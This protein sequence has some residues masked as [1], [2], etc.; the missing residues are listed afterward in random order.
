MGDQLCTSDLRRETKKKSRK[1]TLRNCGP[2]LSVSRGQRWLCNMLFS[3]HYRLS[4]C[5]GVPVSRHS[6]RNFRRVGMRLIAFRHSS[7]WYIRSAM[8]LLGSTL[9]EIEL[10]AFS[11]FISRRCC[12]HCLLSL[13]LC[14]SLSTAR[15]R[16]W[17]IRRRRSAF[18][19]AYQLI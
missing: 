4:V 12:F 11:E 13:L 3:C 19:V 6:Q 16:N 1:L 10:W 14:V 17:I 5:C 2:S 15:H 9:N 7:I 8:Q 18:F